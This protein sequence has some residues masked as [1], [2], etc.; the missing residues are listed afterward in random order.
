MLKL[1]YAPLPLPFYLITWQFD[2][3]GISFISI[4][5]LLAVSSYTNRLAPDTFPTFIL[6][7][8]KSKQRGCNTADASIWRSKRPSPPRDARAPQ[9]R[10]GKAA[11][12][13]M[14]T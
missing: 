3:M 6:Q 4:S 1:A 8:R 7:A 2:I 11:S 5:I 10:A 14:M 12:C 9:R 13:K